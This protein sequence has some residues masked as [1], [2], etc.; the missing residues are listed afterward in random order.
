M[1]ALGQRMIED[2]QLRG[3]SPKTQRA[4]VRTVWQLAEY[5]HRFPDQVGEE[6]S[7]A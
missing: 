5:Y 7:R 3:L 2:M 1:T 6:E 4:Y